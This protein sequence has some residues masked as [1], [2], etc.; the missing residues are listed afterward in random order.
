MGCYLS[1]LRILYFFCPQFSQKPCK[2]QKW[3]TVVKVRNPTASS[4]FF[5]IDCI[6][7]PEYRTVTN[8]ETV[9][10]EI[11]DSVFSMR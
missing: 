1:T 2:D 8:N 9:A 7:T 11:I 3:I 5:W 10:I 4:G 6:N